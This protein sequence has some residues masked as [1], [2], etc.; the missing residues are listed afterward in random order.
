MPCI[1]KSKIG[2]VVPPK[3]REAGSNELSDSSNSTTGLSKFTVTH[4]I[5]TEA[6][7]ICLKKSIA[8]TDSKPSWLSLINLEAN[9][10]LTMLIKAKKANAC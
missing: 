9:P 4:L 3:M 8:K 1:P 10:M 5:R 6:A 7:L 2:S